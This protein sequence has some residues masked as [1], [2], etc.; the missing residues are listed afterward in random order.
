MIP[1]NQL[2]NRFYLQSLNRIYSNSLITF[3]FRNCLKFYHKDGSKS[4]LD[5]ILYSSSKDYSVNA[6]LFYDNTSSTMHLRLLEYEVMHEGSSK[7]Y[8]YP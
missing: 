8:T 4:D 3:Y 7:R 6:A 2:L 5:G 1:F